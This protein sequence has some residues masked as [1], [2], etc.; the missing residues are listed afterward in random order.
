VQPLIAGPRFL[1]VSPAGAPL[2]RTRPSDG[3]AAAP[4]AVRSSEQ[5]GGGASVDLSEGRP[6]MFRRPSVHYGGAG[7]PSRP[8]RRRRRF[9]KAGSVRRAC[10]QELALDGVRCLFPRR[11]F[12]ASSHLAV[13]HRHHNPV[14]VE[15]EVSA[16]PSRSRRQF[17]FQPSE[18]SDRISSC[19]IHED[20]RGFSRWPSCAPELAPCL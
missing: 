9:G 13:E 15:V 12:A 5:G 16:R 20:V 4:H 1:A 6:M 11:G 18:P 8:I 17:F 14:G 10:R 3:A 19:A 2:K 7:D